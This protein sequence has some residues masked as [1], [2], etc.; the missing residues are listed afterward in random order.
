MKFKKL[1]IALFAIAPM[2]IGGCSRKPASSSE[3][4]PT[5]SQEPGHVHSFD[6]FGICSCGEIQEK[7]GIEFVTAGD[8]SAHQHLGG[9]VA[10]QFKLKGYAGH[11][12]TIGIA[13]NFNKTTAKLKWVEGKTVKTNDIGAG[14]FTP[15]VTGIYYLHIETDEACTEEKECYIKYAYK[16]GA[17]HQYNDLG[18][19]ECGKTDGYKSMNIDALTPEFDS[20]VGTIH[21]FKYQFHKDHKYV[22]AGVT[23]FPANDVDVYYFQKNPGQW[24]KESFD[25]KGLDVFNNGAFYVAPQTGDYCLVIKATKVTTHAAFKLQID[26]NSHQYEEWGECPCGQFI[27]QTINTSED[28]SQKYAVGDLAKGEKRYFRWKVTNNVY[29]QMYIGGDSIAVRHTIGLFDSRGVKLSTSGYNQTISS[30]NLVINK[31]YYLI[32]TNPDTINASATIWIRA[33]QA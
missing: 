28:G 9:K 31:Y 11:G 14:D 2:I 22:A 23:S 18:L 27:G 32:V 16:V 15:E 12:I 17:E 29:N 26:A 25:K 20:E 21:K 7:E 4:E 30:P 10:A 33:R 24:V 1:I 5:S 19:C 13:Y 8:E 3:K 6:E